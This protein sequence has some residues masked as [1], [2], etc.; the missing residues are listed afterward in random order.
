M[1]ETRSAAV[2]SVAGAATVFIQASLLL[3]P[4]LIPDAGESCAA[5][6]WLV[7]A[8]IVSGTGR[9]NGF[10]AWWRVLAVLW[11]GFGACV[12]IAESYFKNRPTEF[13]AGLAVGLGLVILVKAWSRLPAS[14]IYAANTLIVLLVALPLADL[15][16]SPADHLNKIPAPEERAYSF[17]VA[18]AHPDA[19]VRW[20]GAYVDQVHGLF[21][22]VETHDPRGV[23][24]F[25]LKPGSTGSF[26]D[27]QI[28]IN[29]KGFRGREIRESHEGTYRIVALGESTTFGFTLTREGQPWPELLE[30]LIHD[31]LHPARPV[32]VI[33][34]GVPS[35]NLK[36]NCARLETEILPLKPDMI[37][38]YHGANGFSLL[39]AGDQPPPEIPPPIYQRRP[40]TVLA[41][42]EYH[43]KTMVY[44]RR[45]AGE[46][47]RL[48]QQILQPMKSEYASCYRRVISVAATNHVRLVLATYSMAANAR[49]EPCVISFYEERF[50]DIAWQIKANGIHSD[51]VRTL[52]G[53]NPSVTLVDTRSALDGKFDDFID[54]MHFS[55]EG[56][57]VM[58]DA[59]FAGIRSVLEADLDDKPS[60]D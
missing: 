1:S 4:G 19:L 22:T 33:N 58:A 54:L 36:D 57:R 37:I 15:A 56:E 13:Y 59:M 7:A 46:G 32:E 43:F 27:S 11:A 50:P 5:I 40:L 39:D 6:S 24:K 17:A 30:K 42:C 49:S 45:K 10:R 51:I 52:A 60:K 3:R 38:S 23:P 48:A 55:P 9:S 35:L 44:R 47:S 25:R 34:A 12:W 28:V 2:L 31:R 18:A 29:S 41:G 53:M 26:F 16:S 14:G 8:A 21:R 20:W